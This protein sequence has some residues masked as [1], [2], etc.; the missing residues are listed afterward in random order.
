MMTDSPPFG[1]QLAAVIVTVSIL[2]GGI[3]GMLFAWQQWTSADSPR[4][5]SLDLPAPLAAAAAVGW[6]LN[7]RITG[8][9][10]MTLL[11]ELAEQG[12]L[13]LDMREGWRLR[14]TAAEPLDYDRPDGPPN[15]LVTL[16]NSIRHTVPEDRTVTLQAT[17]TPLRQ[18]LP[19]VAA[20]IAMAQQQPG[21]LPPTIRTWQ[22]TAFWLIGLSILVGYLSLGIGWSR[23]G[24]WAIGPAVALLAVGSGLLL[25]CNWIWRRSR[26]LSE[27]RDGWRQYQQSVQRLA[28]AE[29]SEPL[30]QLLDERFALLVALGSAEMILAKLEQHG[31]LLPAWATPR[32][33]PLPPEIERPL[34]TVVRV[35]LATPRVRTLSSQ[36]LLDVPSMAQQFSTAVNG[37]DHMLNLPAL[38]FDNDDSRITLTLRQRGPFHLLNWP[39]ETTLRQVWG[40]IFDRMAL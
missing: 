7:Q 12:L 2:L 19:Q 30:Q 8:S 39:R 20:E 33:A 37:L 21:R 16:F 15:Y 5:D 3:V 9:L 35:P 32:P 22:T 17:A 13:Q 34:P 24:A 1:W 6:L 14:R 28:K 18:A 23:F 26:R 29:G 36:P 11:V 40:D 25:I 10:V 38:D 31:G 4:D 27:Q